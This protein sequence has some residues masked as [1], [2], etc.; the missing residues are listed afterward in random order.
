MTDL[1]EVRNLTRE[2]T[3]AYLDYKKVEGTI[4]GDAKKKHYKQKNAVAEQ[5]LKNYA[6]GL[7]SEVVTT[8]RGKKVCRETLY[9]K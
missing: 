2:A 6:A 3:N 1:Y 4:V 8:A 9:D 5:A 7:V